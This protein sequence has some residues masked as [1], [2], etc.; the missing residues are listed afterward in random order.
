MD[1]IKES[2]GDKSSNPARHI[3]GSRAMGI[4]QVDTV[5]TFDRKEM[6]KF[7]E[8]AMKFE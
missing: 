8:F 5:A 4:Y 7:L 1:G 2:K 3:A 6:S